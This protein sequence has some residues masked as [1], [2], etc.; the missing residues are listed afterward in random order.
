MNQRVPTYTK[1]RPDAAASDFFADMI[2]KSGAKSRILGIERAFADNRR[3][4]RA[5]GA[6]RPPW[7]APAS[8]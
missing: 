1:R 5:L 4:L 3:Q 7:Q 8:G 2:K 6:V